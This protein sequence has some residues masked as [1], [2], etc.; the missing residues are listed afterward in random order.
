[1]RAM[2]TSE[3][4]EFLEA[5][6]RTAKVAT[7][8][9]DGTPHVVPVWFCLDDDEL[10]FTTSSRSVKARNLR[11]DP[12]VAVT[13]DEERVPFAF[14]TIADLAT[15][16]LQPEDLLGWTT[17]IARRYVGESRADEIG[18]RNYELDDLLV[19]IPITSG[20]GFADLIG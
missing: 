14:V 5:G 7:V 19:R 16:L 18:R 3:V 20:R 1:V 11:R 17:R 4:Q 6:T 10:V 8:R 15:C 12:H 9:A 2:S 13:V